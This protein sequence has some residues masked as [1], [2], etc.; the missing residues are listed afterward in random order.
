MFK[1]EF[2]TDT[3]IFKSS[4]VFEYWRIFNLVR[5]QVDAG[6]REGTIQDTNGN[7]IGHFEITED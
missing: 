4:P 5:D 7:T 1:L 2:R 3:A 6:A